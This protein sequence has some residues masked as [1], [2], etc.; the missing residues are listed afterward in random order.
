MPRLRRCAR[1]PV[2][3]PELAQF[4][5][6]VGIRPAC[7]ELDPATRA[8]LERGLRLTELLGASAS[9][10]ALEDEVLVLLPA[11]TASWTM[12]LGPAAR[13]GP[14]SFMRTS[15]GELMDTIAT[16]QRLSKR[17]DQLRLAIED[18]KSTGIY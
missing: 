6:A 15:H 2:G 13:G 3:P 8:Q 1:W 5:R 16:G 12:C 9:A 17:R 4:R 10:H 7:S 14:I 18:F 11:S